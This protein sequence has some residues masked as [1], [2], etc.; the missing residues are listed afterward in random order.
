ML[1]LLAVR[2]RLA[3]VLGPDCCRGEARVSHQSRHEFD[4]LSIEIAVPKPTFAIEC[5]VGARQWKL[6]VQH[7]RTDRAIRTS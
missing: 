1:A 6:T 7:V 5:L 3:T 4:Q 2:R